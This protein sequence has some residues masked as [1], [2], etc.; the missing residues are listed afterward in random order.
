[1]GLAALGI[2][3]LDK[4]PIAGIVRM[5]EVSLSGRVLA[6]TAGLSVLTGL[7]FGLMPALRAYAM[8]IAAGMR[9]GARG[10]VSHRRLNSALVAVQ[11][12]LSL[13]LLIGAGLLLKSFQRLESVNLGFTAENTLTMVAT[14]PRVKYDN[15][16]KSLRFYESSLERLRHSPGISAVGLTT[17]LPF[18]DGGN[19]DGI[20]IEGQNTIDE[21]MVT[22]ESVSVERKVGDKV[23]GST[24]NQTGS[25]L[26]QA[27]KVGNETVLAQI[28]AMVSQAQRSRAPIQR[29]AAPNAIQ[30]RQAATSA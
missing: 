8:G 11:F 3:M 4:L 5:E 2:R 23:I 22:G 13:I 17:N 12:A 6:F 21:S 18:A 27:E 19:V 25:F 7:L 10:T 29:L 20:I 28:V 14:L 1:M 9:E 16:E 30:H 24:I 26:M 15:E